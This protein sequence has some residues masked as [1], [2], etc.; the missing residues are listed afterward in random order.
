M[1][2][3]ELYDG[4][5]FRKHGHVL[6]DMLADHLSVIKDHDD[7]K[8]ITYVDPDENYKNWDTINLTSAKEIFEAILGNSIHLHNPR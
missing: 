5:T 3:E 2:L 8:V 4:E 7:K 6:I 1:S